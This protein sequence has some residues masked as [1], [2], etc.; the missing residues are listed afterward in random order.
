MTLKWTYVGFFFLFFFG[1]YLVKSVHGRCSWIW[2]ITCKKI[3]FLTCEVSERA[4]ERWFSSWAQFFWGWERD[5]DWITIHSRQ[6]IFTLLHPRSWLDSAFA[7][8]E[9]RVK[10]KRTLLG[11]ISLWETHCEPICWCNKE[12]SG[13]NGALLKLRG[14][15]LFAG[16]WAGFLQRP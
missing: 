5:S 11:F 6:L 14:G 16:K 13:L 9:V 3:R 10:V 8:S 12:K 15:F 7:A 1:N 2:L 4:D